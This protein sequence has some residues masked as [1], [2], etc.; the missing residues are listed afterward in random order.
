MAKQDKKHKKTQ[1]RQEPIFHFER[2]NL[3]LFGAGLLIIILGYIALA[4]GP[5]NSFWSLTLAPILLVLGY[6]VVIPLSLLYHKR[7]KK[8]AQT[9]EG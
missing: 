2:E 6:C 9:P 3:L 1:K 7:E 4:Q 5:W 8:Q